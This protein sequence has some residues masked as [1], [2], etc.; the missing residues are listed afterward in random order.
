MKLWG[1]RFEKE[2]EGLVHTFSSSLS[3]DR[4]LALYD[5][6]VSEAHALALE[7]CGVLS[8]REREDIVTALRDVRGEMEEGS[9]RFS[10]D[11]DIHSAVERSLVERIGDA[12]AKL[13]AGRSRNDQV[14]ADMRLY[15]MDSSARICLR[16]LE[17]MRV[18]LVK[19]EENLGAIYALM[20]AAGLRSVALLPYN[21]ASAA[22]Y[23]W[24]D[25][26]YPL[27]AERQTP[28]QLN[29]MLAAARREGL[30]AE[31]G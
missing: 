8:E 9:F 24:L 1:G 3:F 19:A 29:E 23:A 2:T 27:V 17:L 7:G 25:R 30:E 26:P 15:L 5:L 28:A 10:G 13:R 12:G 20:R 14:A 22:K 21:E 18:V 11:E 16:L 4:R 31:I 6:A